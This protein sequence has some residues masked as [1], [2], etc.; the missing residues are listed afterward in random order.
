M[1]TAAIKALQDA[2]HIVIIQAE[3]PDGD[4]L[5]SSLALEELL[6]AQGK[7]VHLF[8][9]VTM[10]GY[11]RYLSGWDRV[12]DE[13]PRRVDA[14]IIVDTASSALLEKAL[15]AEVRT[16]LSRMPVLVFDHHLT[17]GDLPFSQLISVTDPSRV[18]TAELLADFAQQAGWPLTAA[19][20]EPLL[21][22]ILADSL[23]LTTSN[24]TATSLRIVADLI[25]AGAH[26]A[27][28]ESR[29]REYMR[30]APDILAYKG[31]LLQRVEYFLAGALAVI[32]IPWDEIQQYSDR[33]NPSVLVL[34]EMRLV[35]DVRV[36]VAIKTY[37]DGRLTGKI[38]T[39][40]DAKIAETIAGYFGGGGHGYTAGFK[41][42]EDYETTIKELVTA[43]DKAL[44]SLNGA[45][46]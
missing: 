14:A 7:T 30:K 33:Y 40:P 5:G 42:Y 24:T 29:R 16:R 1:Y 44:A 22:A 37:P 15:S 46:A 9:R 13:F 26:P 17:S 4:S 43:T 10:P 12:S 31:L 32:H 11:L 8:C 34:D 20:A 27:V 41:I 23:G 6:A 35:T 2:E 38:R 19:A 28:I 18:A 25:E 36:A 21:A 3:N 39:N 45:A